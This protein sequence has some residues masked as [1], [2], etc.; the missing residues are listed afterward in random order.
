MRQPRKLA[1]WVATVLTLTTYIAY[2]PPDRNRRVTSF[3][4]LNAARLPPAGRAAPREPGRLG[5]DGLPHVMERLG[6]V[7]IGT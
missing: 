4:Q 6:P 5:E 2:F 7:H 3:H 1:T